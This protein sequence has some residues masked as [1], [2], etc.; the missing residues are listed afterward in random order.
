MPPKKIAKYINIVK[1][2]SKDGMFKT[3]IISTI[4]P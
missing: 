3:G 1:K 2:A 4:T